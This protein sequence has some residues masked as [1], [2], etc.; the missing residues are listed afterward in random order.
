[1]RR[2]ADSTPTRRLLTSLC[3]APETKG[4]HF[5]AAGWGFGKVLGLC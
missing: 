4:E 3:R 2:G 1:M 5:R